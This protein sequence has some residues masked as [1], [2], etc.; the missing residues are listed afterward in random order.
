MQDFPPVTASI[1]VIRFA[2]VSSTFPDIMNMA[3]ELMNEVKKTGKNDVRFRHY[4]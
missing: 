1:G 3:D 4:D 2:R